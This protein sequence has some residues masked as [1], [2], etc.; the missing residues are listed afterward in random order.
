MGI[1]V[2]RAQRRLKIELVSVRRQRE[3]AHRVS[4]TPARSRSPGCRPAANEHR[5]DIVDSAGEIRVG[6][7]QHDD[8]VTQQISPAVPFC[9]RIAANNDRDGR[10]GAALPLLIVLCSPVRRRIAMAPAGRVLDLPFVPLLSGRAMLGDSR[11][12]PSR[13]VHRHQARGHSCKGATVSQWASLGDPTA[14]MRAADAK[15]G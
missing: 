1:G 11:R 6:T 13:R 9:Q 10:P 7:P 4:R 2:A 8:L 14:E 5:A 3:N 12:A 15:S